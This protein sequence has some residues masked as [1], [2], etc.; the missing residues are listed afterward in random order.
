MLA[1]HRHHEYNMP[2]EA[3]L[4]RYHHTQIGY[5]IIMVFALAIFFITIVMATS[6]FNWIACSVL[7]I[8]GISLLLFN[9]LTVAI[10]EEVLEV[11][12]G[13]NLIRKTFYLKDIESCE[14]VKNPWYYGWGIHL[15]P[16]GWLFNV[17]GFSAIEIKLKSGKR[18]RIGTDVPD[19]LEKAIRE[20]KV[21]ALPLA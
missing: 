10:G 6:V 18:Y 17:S 2:K 3:K 20:A 21:I 7:I 4:M 9:T 13:P 11:R 15:T 8:L 19:E 14:V 5:L 16:H 12:F 1:C